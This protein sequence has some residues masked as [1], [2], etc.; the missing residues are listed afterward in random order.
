VT[1][2]EVKDRIPKMAEALGAMLADD[3]IGVFKHAGMTLNDAS[4]SVSM[5]L[6][7]KSGGPGVRF[8]LTVEQVP[9]AEDDDDD[10][11]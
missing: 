11:D 5:T 9:A 7:P 1:L 10:E 6:R 2:D 8:S 4:P 3:C